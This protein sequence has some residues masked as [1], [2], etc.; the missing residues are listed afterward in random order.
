MVKR[1][2]RLLPRQSEPHVC[3]DKNGVA[4]ARERER[5]MKEIKSV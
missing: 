1:P 5:E 4:L 2:R 3:V